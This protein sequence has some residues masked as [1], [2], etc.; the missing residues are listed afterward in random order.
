MYHGPSS[1]YRLTTRIR[2]EI[3]VS[4]LYGV[5]VDSQAVEVTK[6]SL[7]LKL[8]EDESA[9]VINRFTKEFHEY[10]LLDL[11]DNVKRGNSMVSPDIREVAAFN[12]LAA[13]QQDVLN[14]F[15]FNTAF[16]D[17]AKCGGFDVVIGNPRYVLMQG[18]FRNDFLYQYLTEHFAAQYKLD[19]HNVFIEQSIRLTQRNGYTTLITPSNYLT[20]NYLDRLRRVMLETTSMQ[21]ISDIL[22][23]GL[24]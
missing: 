24:R 3:L 6:L 11:D 5:D 14:Y 10:I 23:E 8:L 13:E 19:T 4:C 15:D 9:E 21:S 20:N 1:D 22:R 7:L 18:E 12:N 2:R 16:P 17:A